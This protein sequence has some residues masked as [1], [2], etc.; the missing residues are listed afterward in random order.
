MKDWI[1]GF[2][3]AWGMFLAIP[4]PLKIWRESA[5]SKM[6]CC[7]P[8]AG[9]VVGAVW[10][11]AAYLARFLPATVGGLLLAAAPWLATGFLHL[12]G[13]MDVCD[14]VLSRRDLPER[15]RILKD[16]HCG[17]FAVIGMVLL[18]CGQWS[19][20]MANPMVPL[21]PLLLLP[22]ASRASAALAVLTLPPMESS[23]Y[24]ARCGKKATYTA[25]AARG[26]AAAVTVPLAVW[27]SFAPL[28]SAAGYGAAL[29][30]AYRQLGGMSGDVSGFALTL[31]ELCGLA[32][33][34]LVR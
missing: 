34:T 4:C 11:L 12:D 15:R 33:L 6:L 26:L 23:Q 2:F 21:L 31:G 25:F 32:A 10:V 17:A 27:G 8:L 20:A 28:A 3:M 7:L 5:R 22:V 13:F 1:C 19:V 29:W 14:A 24:A 9:G 16:S 18:A 30:Y